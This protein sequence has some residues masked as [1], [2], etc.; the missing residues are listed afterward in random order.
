[1]GMSNGF[2]INT[3]FGGGGLSYSVNLGGSGF[4]GGF[5]GGYNNNFGNNMMGSSFSYSGPGY[6]SGFNN[7]ATFSYNGVWNNY[8]DQFLRNE[9]DRVYMLYDFN[10][11]G[12]L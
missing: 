9:I 6:N 1:M 11:S 3:G 4:G 12:Q 8:H 10:R 2:G 5:G 7:V